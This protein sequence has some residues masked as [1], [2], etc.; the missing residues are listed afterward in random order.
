VKKKKTSDL[1]MKKC[2][3]LS[4]SAAAVAFFAAVPAQ[5]A[6]SDGASIVL[7]QA[8]PVAERI[9]VIGSREK[10]ERIPG[11][12]HLLEPQ[13]LEKLKYYDIHRMLRL[14][15]GVNIQEEDGY[16]LRPNIGLRGSGSERSS[17]ITLMEDGVLIAP[18]PY[19][20]PSAYYFPTAGRMSAIE[21]RKGTAAVKFGPRTVGGAINLVSTPIPEETSGFADLR[22]GTDN[23]YVAHANAAYVS[24]QFAALIET[25]QSGADGFKNLDNGGDTG[26]SIQDYV[27]KLRYSTDSQA[28]VF[29]SF[30]LKLGYTEN[31]S[32]ETYLGLTDEDFAE[33]PYRRYAAS[34][35]DRMETEHK[36]IQLTHY[37]EATDNI[38]ITTVAYYNEFARDWFKLD[39]L[40]FGEGRFRPSSVFDDPDNF[41]DVLAVFRGEADSPD[42]ALQ[43]R[44]NNRSYESWGVQTVIGMGFNTGTAKHDLEIGLRWHQ[45]EEDRLQNR[46]N[47][48]M[49]DGV[50]ILTSV[51]PI[52]SQGNRVGKAQAFAAFVQDEIEI[53]RWTLL[54][55]LRFEKIKLERIDYLSTD[56]DRSEGASGMRQNHVNAVIPG[57]GATFK[58]TDDLT[59][60][61]GVHRGFAPPGTSTR[62]GEASVEKS[63]NYELGLRYMHEWLYVEVVG[64]YN[65]YSN[66]LGTC[67][68]STGCTGQTGDQFNGGTASV[69]G[70]EATVSYDIVA[71]ESLQV[72]LRLTYTYTDT[73]FKTA[74]ND[75]FWGNVQV[76]DE[77]PYIPKHQLHASIGLEATSWGATLGMTYVSDIRTETGQGAIP[78]MERVDSHVVFDLSA[79]YQLNEKVRLYA[80]AEN[81]F[82]ADYAVARR[83]YGLRP[84]KPFTVV[85]GVSFNF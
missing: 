2:N 68:N 15:P 11:S 84:G 34:Q 65:D 4:A 59:L 5:A 78:D 69:K 62:D 46:E 79:Y 31:N 47:F 40:D 23:F 45:D 55:G 74:F 48:K 76:G 14:V 26:F 52:G 27:V 28:D 82:D 77:M 56:P 13:E 54:P 39:D 72:P 29:Q 44:H 21:V 58:A 80:T 17:R 50:M 85:G 41:T 3:L 10:K 73:K 32:D 60:L 8:T 24:D 6:D 53:G 35:N 18:A 38:D 36:Q 61:A 37:I 71:S 49:E 51:D 63:W 57:F 1:T 64:F 67:T 16:G 7:A 43:L 20:A 19:A 42:D 25:Y 66:I 33:T 70:V 9:Y 12:A 75:G 30:E 83:P 22:F 81:L